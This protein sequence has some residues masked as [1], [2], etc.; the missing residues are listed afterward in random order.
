MEEENAIIKIGNAIIKTL[1][2]ASGRGYWNESGE[3]GQR[4]CQGGNP[5]SLGPKYREAA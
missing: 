2:Y 4:G 5:M 1:K 3:R